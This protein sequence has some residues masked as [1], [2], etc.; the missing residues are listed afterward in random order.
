LVNLGSPDSPTEAD[1]RR[2]LDEFLMDPCVLDSPWLIRRF[3]VS[4]F[5][6]PK[7]P[8]ESAHAYRSVWTDQGSPLLVTSCALAEKV[9]ENLEQPVALGMRYGS[10][11]IQEGLRDLMRRSQGGLDEILLF[12]LY[13]HFAMSSYETVVIATREAMRKLGIDLTLRVVPPF[14]EDPLYIEA[15][16][17][18][19][20]DY[21]Q[22]DWDYLLFSYHGL[23]ERHLRKSDPT[24][25]HCL[26][27]P[28]CCSKPSQAHKTCYRHQAFRTTE[29]FVKKA[30]IPEGKYSVAFQSRLGR[31]PWLKPYTDF[32]LERL[33]KQGI[34]KILVICPAFVSDCLETLEEIGMR[35]KESFEQ[36]G[37]EE[38]R[39][40]YC[41]NE[42]PAWIETATEF[43]RR[44]APLA[45][46]VC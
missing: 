39:L 3:V 27:T 19:A 8:K 35:G 18:S 20:R 14:Y 10:P 13:P 29:E 31:D 26:A 23:P 9:R 22:G 41:M 1:V 5:I 37:G 43:C 21:L 45:S 46:E 7:R 2:Y 30:G 33:A 25:K 36:A 6:L 11:S 44:P 38:L 28:D 40:V 42:H 17:G 32:E 24:G 15:L 12:P 34:R 4:C 16:V